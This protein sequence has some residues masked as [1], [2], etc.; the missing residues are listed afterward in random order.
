MV[1]VVTKLTEISAQLIEAH[2]YQPVENKIIMCPSNIN[3][4]WIFLAA[5]GLKLVTYV[6]GMDLTA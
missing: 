1:M 4:V 3:D 5:N 2:V 6:L